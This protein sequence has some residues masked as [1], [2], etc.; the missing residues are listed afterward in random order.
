MGMGENISS[1]AVKFPGF[2]NPSLRPGWGR[3]ISGAAHVLL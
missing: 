2:S 1:F 3:F